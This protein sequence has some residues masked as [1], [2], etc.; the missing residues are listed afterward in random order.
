MSLRFNRRHGERVLHAPALELAEVA[1]R[2]KS[3]P[4]QAPLQPP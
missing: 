2:G 3:I 4:P 1:E